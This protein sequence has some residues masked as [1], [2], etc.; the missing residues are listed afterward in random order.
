M[1]TPLAKKKPQPSQGSAQKKPY[2][3]GHP[4]SQ[5][6]IEPNPQGQTM[7]PQVSFC[8][9]IEELNESESHNTLQ[10][11]QGNE[12]DKPRFTFNIGQNLQEQMRTQL[13]QLP[14]AKDKHTTG[15]RD[16]RADSLGSDSSN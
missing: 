16:M 10:A 2:R 8:E 4:A 1:E 6:I 5:D 13:Q 11:T 12:R 7:N 9:K 3:R 15:K 14:A